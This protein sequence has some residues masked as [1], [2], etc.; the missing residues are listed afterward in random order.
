MR[1]IAILLISVFGLSA[2][3][4]KVGSSTA[5]SS[6]GGGNAVVYNSS[7]NAQA[8]SSVNSYRLL[9]LDGITPIDESEDSILLCASD[10]SWCKQTCISIYRPVTRWST[11]QSSWLSPN[12]KCIGAAMSYP[13]GSAIPRF[14]YWIGN[15]IFNSGSSVAG[16]CSFNI[17]SPD[18]DGRGY[19]DFVRGAPS[20]YVQ[21]F[22][23]LSGNSISNMQLL[24]FNPPG[25]FSYH[26]S[27]VSNGDITLQLTNSGGCVKEA[28]IGTTFQ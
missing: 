19:F 23:D 26:D 2:C 14:K 28:N 7:L 20:Y 15:F 16:R 12:G 8:Q 24:I 17:N 25:I 6:T 27:S 9:K 13:D 3:L 10:G 22:F 4:D 18:F 5:D 1:K 21:K 11:F